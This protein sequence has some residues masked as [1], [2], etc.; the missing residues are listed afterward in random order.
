MKGVCC[1]R[2][3]KAR[4]NKGEDAVAEVIGESLSGF[5]VFD[6]HSGKETAFAAAE[7]LLPRLMVTDAMPSE[8]AVEA[9]FWAVDEEMGRRGMRDGT[10]ATTLIVEAVPGCGLR[11]LLACCGDSTALIVHIVSDGKRMHREDA[12]STRAVCH[13]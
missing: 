10:T 12:E 4:S 1:G 2:A 9:A 8:V 7:M 13:G 11:C 6:G 3:C 5:G